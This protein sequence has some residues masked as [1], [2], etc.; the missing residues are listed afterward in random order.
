MKN[1]VHFKLARGILLYL[2][3]FMYYSPQIH[4]QLI[5][6]SLEE[7]CQISS[8]IVKMEVMT[9][10]SYWN[11]TQT[12]IFTDVGI[13]ILE[14]YKGGLNINDEITFSLIGGTVDDIRTFVVG[15]P[16]YY[17]GERALMFFSRVELGDGGENFVISGLS[18]GKFKI[19]KDE[20]NN[21]DVVIR[22]QIGIPLKLRKEGQT[23]QLTDEVAFPLNDFTQYIVNFTRNK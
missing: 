14:K 2:L 11:S 16:G 18:Q 9:T 3:L 20:K 23:I 5:E 19:I 22:E 6:L 8:D 21:E 15:Q 1:G 12:R 13:R 7:L 10:K 4:A 17:P